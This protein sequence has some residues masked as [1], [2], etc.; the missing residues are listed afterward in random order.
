MKRLRVAIVGFGKLGK[1]CAEAVRDDEQLFLAGIV[2]RPES[3]GEKLP[4]NM[5]Q[6]PIV[7]HTSELGEVGVALVCVPTTEALVV[8]RDLLQHRISIVECATLHGKALQEHKEEL[9]RLATHHNVPAIVGA[10]WDPGALSL[11][12]AIF[13]L[14]IPGGQTETSWHTAASMHHTTA[15]KSVRG[16]KEALS[17][18][19]RTGDGKL[20]RYVYVELEKGTDPANVESAIRSDHLFLGEETLV[21]P[22][23]SIKT[24]EEE[25]RGV[26][27]ERRGKAA[28]AGHQA[29]LLEARYSEQALAG[30]VMA[31]AARAIPLC[32]RGAVS[33]FDL[34]L[35]NLWGMLKKRGEQEW[36]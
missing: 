28:G 30:A 27:L 21:F 26:L 12:R 9:N 24:L 7:P 33:L 15:A 16:V 25:G 3:L 20:Q 2:R 4:S 18:E 32:G 8:A 35:G 19:L 36:F 14:L 1:A 17:T 34:P 11:F 31:A 6:V 29:L 10:G 13:D 5:E 23:E 22:V